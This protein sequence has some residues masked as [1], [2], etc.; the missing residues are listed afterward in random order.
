M[1]SVAIS[2]LATVNARADDTDTPA[3]QPAT[4]PLRLTP[5]PGCAHVLIDLKNKQI[6]VDCESLNAHMPLEFFCVV[7][8]G[9]EHESILRTDARPS[10]IHFGLLAMGL[11]PGEPAHLTQPRSHLVSSH[12]SAAEDQLPIFVEW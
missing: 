1:L 2:L 9:Q 11:Q 3:T 4:R 5:L 12:R 7:R 6:R 10:V 8:G